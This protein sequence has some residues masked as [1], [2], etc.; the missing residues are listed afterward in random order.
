MSYMHIDNLYKNQDILLFKECYALE[1]IHGT[2]AHISWNSAILNFFAGGVSHEQFVSLFDKESL[3]KSFR[4]IG[5]DP[6]VV[7]GE[8]YGG[9]CQKMSGVY[10][11]ELRFVVFDVK[12]GDCWLS[13]PQAEDFASQ[14]GLEFVSYAK[15]CTNLEDLDYQRNLPSFQ[16]ERNGMGL[17]HRREGVVLRPPIEVTKNNGSRIIAKHKC[18]EFRETKSPRK[19]SKDK[20]EVLEKANAIAEE[21]VTPMR[22][23]HV[24]DKIEEPSIEKMRNI[25]IGMCEDVKREADGEIV[26]SREVEK[27]VSRATAVMYKKSLQ[28]QLEQGETNGNV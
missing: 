20:L 15:V 22:L 18:E 1:K 11:K 19:V 3:E 17:G 4:E 7:F 27:A 28:E 14:L 12:V 23:S 16:A 8:A 26:W 6:V 9:K 25:I 21:W 24:L 13:V 2:S 5:V 10:G